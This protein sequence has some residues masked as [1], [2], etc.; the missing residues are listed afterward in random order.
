MPAEWT[1]RDD[2]ECR[3]NTKKEKPTDSRDNTK[4]LNKTVA[5]GVTTEFR[6]RWNISKVAD[7]EERI[8]VLL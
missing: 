7:E 4:N 3:D 2:I 8:I 5:T 6:E 1:V